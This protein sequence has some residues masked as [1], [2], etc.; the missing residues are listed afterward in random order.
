MIPEYENLR[1]S[2]QTYFDRYLRERVQAHLGPLFGGIRKSRQVEGDRWS[3]QCGD[4]Q[5]EPKGFEELSTQMSMPF[6]ELSVLS[7]Q[8]VHEKLD[9]SAKE[10]A[11]V[12]IRS[13]LAKM[14]ESAQEHGNIH[15]AG[16][17]Q[18]TPEMI[19]EIISGMDVGFRDGAPQ[20]QL[21]VPPNMEERARKAWG[22]LLADPELKARL[23][24]VIQTKYEVWC[25]SEIDRSLD[26]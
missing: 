13:F 21:V 1:H 20:F 19:I 26:G 11:D 22:D 3:L 14:D 16:G 9:A 2:F 12:M 10:F 23:N 15:D 4:I 25:A 8:Q 24:S 7:I 18:L 17:R 6:A 5:P